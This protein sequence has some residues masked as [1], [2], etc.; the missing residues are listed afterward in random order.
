[1]SA[2]F[3]APVAWMLDRVLGEPRR[4]H[5]LVGFGRL[6]ASAERALLREPDAD[7]VKRVKGVLAVLL[8]LAP[9][10]FAAGWHASLPYI[11]AVI[12]ILALY[13]ALGGRSLEQHGNAVADALAAGDIAAARTRLG[14]MVSRDTANLDA[15]AMAR[16][17]VE[18]VLENGN[19]AV[20]GALFWFALAGAP[21]V[22]LYRLS[23]TLD[24]MWGYRNARYLHFGWF[25]ARL[26]DVFNYVPARLTALAYGL[27]GDSRS[28][29]MC[30]RR[31]APL[32]Y[33]PNAGPVMA[34]GAGALGLRLGGPACYGGQ[35]K[36]RPVLGCGEQPQ[37]KDI[38]RALVLVRRASYLWLA[39]MVALQWGW[40]HA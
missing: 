8:L 23:N 15:D 37:S 33:S 30:W 38:G 10:A 7:S 39:I 40:Q 28:A 3:A 29:F 12:E 17:T 21:G 2:L 1:M 20:F 31:Q 19:D 18:S 5:P 35:W 22:V 36:E 24:A 34:S 25:A 14:W 16:A 13:L 32:W 6:A 9:L 26:D 4:L 11:G 27:L